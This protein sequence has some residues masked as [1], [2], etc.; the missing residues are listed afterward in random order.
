MIAIRRTLVGLLITA[1]LVF[2]MGCDT[3]E[4]ILNNTGLST[5][6]V[7]AGLKQALTVGTDST[8]KQ[9]NVT[10]GY[11]GNALI[12]IPMP[13][14]ASNVIEVV[15]AVPGGQQ[16]INDVVLKMNRAAEMAAAE[17]KPIFW[18]AITG[19]TIQ[20]GWNIL[21]GTDT[22]ATS[23]LRTNTTDSLYAA[24]RPHVEQ[25]MTSVGV[26]QAWSTLSAEYNDICALTP[27][28]CNPVDEDISDY[29]TNKA[30]NG[31]FVVVG[32]KETDIRTN[33]AFR[34]TDLLRKVFAEQD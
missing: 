26:Q 4:D 30:L 23:Y 12:K 16:L 3:A 19:M 32:Q 24:Y 29:V 9:L 17:A 14:Y 10:D 1:G 31:L 15:Q 8:T 34:V 28:L 20:D 33:A 18:S 2:Q 5:E 25:A 7:V 21:K 13:D 27:W 11:F 22:A 6:E